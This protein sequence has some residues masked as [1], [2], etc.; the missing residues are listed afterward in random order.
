MI[1]CFGYGRKWEMTREEWK[2]HYRQ[3]RL[4]RPK[5][6]LDSHTVAACLRELYE[7]DYLAKEEAFMRL[8][9]RYKAKLDSQ[10]L[11]R[12][13]LKIEMWKPIAKKRA[14]ENFK[15]LLG[16]K[17]PWLSMMPKDELGGAYFPVPII[18]GSRPR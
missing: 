16:P 7:Y 9:N 10:F 13:Q 11:V 8:V 6:T 15:S 2:D 14:M 12:A 3:I 1:W 4:A 17:N 18:F 5:E